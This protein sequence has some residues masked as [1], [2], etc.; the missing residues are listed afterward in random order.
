M[1][2]KSLFQGLRALSA[3]SFPKSCACCGRSFESAEA[4]L[5]ETIVPPM[6]K[7]FLRA[8]R[9]V[10][11]STLLEVFRNCPCGSTLMDEFADRRDASEHGNLRRLLF[12]QLFESL[13]GDYGF[14]EED[15]RTELLKVVIGE[16]SEQLAELFPQV[17]ELSEIA[18]EQSPN[19]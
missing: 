8:A 17:A 7:S 3:S 2:K 1:D 4:F 5:A 10:D 16:P 9:E 12:R 18:S 19:T 14:T 11:G 15:A 6:A 13:T